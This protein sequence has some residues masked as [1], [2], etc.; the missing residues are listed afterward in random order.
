[1]I[2]NFEVFINYDMEKNYVGETHE[3]S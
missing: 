2:Y 1:L 3:N